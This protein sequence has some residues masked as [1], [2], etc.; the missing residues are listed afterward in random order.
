[1]LHSCRPIEGFTPQLVQPHQLY[2]PAGLDLEPPKAGLI[3]PLRRPDFEARLSSK[4]AV[5]LKLSLFITYGLLDERPGCYIHP[6]YDT[7]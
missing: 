5:T 6:M 7:L 2:S 3:L 4:Q 1:M